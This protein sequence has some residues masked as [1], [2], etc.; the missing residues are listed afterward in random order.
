MMT[1]RTITRSTSIESWPAFVLRATSHSTGMRV[2][3]VAQS[4][5]FSPYILGQVGPK[6]KISYSVLILIIN[7]KLEAPNTILSI[8]F[9]EIIQL[10]SF[11]SNYAKWL[12][13]WNL[14]CQ[15]FFISILLSTIIFLSLI[16]EYL[17]IKKL[18][19]CCWTSI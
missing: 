8:D 14:S 4:A 6:W 7:K 18:K 5:F 19:F 2:T 11:C 16:E 9:V 15:F 13:A 10:K 12:Y 1:C 3:R 17:N